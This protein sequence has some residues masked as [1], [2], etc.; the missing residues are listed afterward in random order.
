MEVV[1]F[2]VETHY[3]AFIECL[4]GW[5]AYTQPRDEVPA[6]GFVALSNG[7]PAAFA[8]IR[9]VECNFGQLD[10]LTSNPKLNP[11]T[12][13]MA[14]DAVV[15]ALITEAKE[16]KLK[17]LTAFTRDANTLTRSRKYGFLPMPSILI[18]LGLKG[19]V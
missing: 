2:H 1:R 18:G 19:D 9:K 3:E 7:I 8:F 17:S 10:G 12:R 6:V 11:E 16:M 15:T 13:D 4:N 14:I 5:G